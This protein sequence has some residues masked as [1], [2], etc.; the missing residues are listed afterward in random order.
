MRESIDISVVI[1]SW[2]VEKQLRRCLSSVMAQSGVAFEVFVVD[3]ASSD[4][5]GEMVKKEFSDAQ[6]IEN[7]QN[8]G[9][10]TA[11]NQV[12]PAARGRHMLL[13]NPDTKLPDDTLR[14]TVAYLDAHRDVGVLG[15]AIL[16][17][18][19][20]VQRSVLRFPTIFSQALVLLKLQ[21][22]TLKPKILQ[23]YYALD[24]DYS[25]ERDV[26][27]VMGAFFAINGEI[28][29]TVGLLDGRFFAW[30]EEVD[31]CKRVQ[32]AGWKIRYTPLFSITHT[33]GQS[34]N[35]LLSIEQQVIFNRSMI[36]YF[37]KH[38]SFLAVGILL[39]LTIPSFGFALAENIIR[40]WYVPKAIR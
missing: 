2:N 3:N 35:Q 17:D 14:K 22:F 39:V 38:H 10:A 4:G 5:S 18:D 20:K 6:L 26:D 1:V 33:G 27:Q 16:H 9:F 29:R 24:F 40:R 28:V 8:V 34:F 15:C 25:Q 21:A 31:Y 12:L 11:N 37:R 36:H 23:Q 19:G 32:K 7:A 13:L 30:F